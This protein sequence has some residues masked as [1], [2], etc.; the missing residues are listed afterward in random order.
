MPNEHKFIRERK[1]SIGPHS[2]PAPD[3]MDYII[4]MSD[5][6]TTLVHRTQISNQKLLSLETS[7]GLKY[8]LKRCRSLSPNMKIALQLTDQLTQNSL[9]IM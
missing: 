5:P 1:Q 8:I 7:N 2:N 4:K 9:I 3:L 6:H